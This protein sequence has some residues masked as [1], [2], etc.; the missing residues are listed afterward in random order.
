[1]AKIG[2]DISDIDKQVNSLQRELK[3]VESSLKTMGDNAVLA[4]QQYDIL[5]KAIKSTEEKLNQLR[6][7]EDAVN[8]A[9]ASGN[10]TDE[11]YRAYQREVEKTAA[12]L[13]D[14]RDK[15]SSLNPALDDST[16]E[17]KANAE[18]LAKADDQVV[19]WAKDL[20]SNLTEALTKSIELIKAFASEVVEVG[21]QFETSMSLVAGTMGI[22]QASEEFQKLEEAAK[23]TGATTRYTASQAAEALNYLALA[24]YDADQSIA[25]LPNVLNMAQS[26]GMDFARSSEM[27]TNATKTLGVDMKEVSAFVDKMA[28]TARS[29]G[30][31][32][33]QLGDAILTVGGT[34]R[35]M[36]GG[37]DEL[38]AALGILADNGIKASE[39][40]TKIRNILLKMAN[41]AKGTK[42]LMKELNVE[43][44]DM[45]GNLRPL[46]DIFGE[47]KQKM[48]DMQMT[49]QERD[50]LLGGAFNSRD[51]AAINA[52]MNTN[53][54]RWDELT[55]K[56]EAARGAAQDM[57]TTLNDNFQGAL[58]QL[59]SAKQAVEIELYQKIQA[60]LAEI[61]NSLADAVRGISTEISEAGF[62]EEFTEAFQ[63]IADAV[64]E[65]LPTI[66]ELF[67]KFSETVVPA[68]GDL[69]AKTV[70]FVADDVLPK[71]I[72]LAEWIADHGE[73]VVHVIEMLVA[74]MVANKV[75][76]FADALK[77]GITNVSALGNVVQAFLPSLTSLGET[78][79]TVVAPA[80]TTMG[81]EAEASSVALGGLAAVGIAAVIAGALAAKDAIEKATDAT[82]EWAKFANGFSQTSNDN[83]ER[84][85]KLTRMAT[86]EAGKT[87][88]EWL[89][90]DK[91]ALSGAQNALREFEKEK[92]ALEAEDDLTLM[93]ADRILELEQQIEETKKNIETYENLISAE[94]KALKK[95][96]ELD[97]YLAGADRRADLGTEGARAEKIALKNKARAAENK[98]ESEAV[99]KEAEQAEREDFANWLKQQEEMWDEKYHWDKENQAMYWIEKEKLLNENKINSKEWWDAYNKTEKALAKIR[100][101]ENKAAAKT[102]KDAAKEA[103]KEAAEAQRQLKEA[104][105]NKEKV[106][107][108]QLE[109]LDIMAKENGWK[110]TELLDAKQALL[111][112]A[113]ELDEYAQRDAEIYAKF[114]KEIRKKRADLTAENRKQAQKDEAEAE[115]K[116]LQNREDA[117]KKRWKELENQADLENWT[118]A[119]LLLEKER[120]LNDLAEKDSELY[121]TY[122]AKIDEGRAA[123]A[124]KGRKEYETEIANRQKDEQKA[125]DAGEKA[126]AKLVSIAEKTKADI[127][128]AGSG[129]TTVTDT[130]GRERLVFSDYSSKIKDLQKY[131]KQL[132][133]LKTLGL[134]DS[135]IA[136]IFQMDFNTRMKY[137][138]ELLNMGSGARAK[139]LNDYEAYQALAGKVANKELSYHNAD[140]AQAIED[141]LKDI[142]ENSYSNGAEAAEAYAK[143]WTD[144]L[145]AHGLAGVDVSQYTKQIDEFKAEN[146]TPEAKSFSALA[147]SINDFTNT[148]AG[149]QININIDNYKYALKVLN[150]VLGKG[151]NSGSKTL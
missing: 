84:Y 23:Q 111:D 43:F 109:E 15:Y 124:K 105:T 61:T 107:K 20:D 93:N 2:L 1:M 51:M 137:I 76:L 128:K 53:A 7:A 62:G 19:Q 9:H 60:P 77:T 85:V 102:E 34:A 71:A 63:K 129:T 118:E 144:Y 69:A 10:L 142:S 143:G 126:A 16:Q 79:G 149:K 88:S 47:I 5:D 38:D 78:A 145:N 64:K 36:A 55:G 103:E 6:A 86:D 125:A 4:S 25:M 42:E 45:E 52:L 72:D 32:M 151:M 50:A 138:D 119:K 68:L 22:D 140:I 54:A 11:E 31:N 44:Y 48:D 127:V 83:L 33:E 91:T 65:E 104:Q 134:S 56:I 101:A 100:T 3:T 49:Q 139:Y 106:L 21:K 35:N 57:G 75:V 70:D 116:D 87:A 114:D 12:S 24:S 37:V 94:E 59:E 30:T 28:V 74:A 27:L 39:G 97:E 130:A 146:P 14:L 135:H 150:M 117:I 58:Y 123:A 96:K 13:N 82:I 98:A 67:K 41:P 73:T 81:I 133:K 148:L 66:I 147:K 132:D 90:A 112:E 40:G 92:A 8:A 115:K 46:G 95:Q 17:I 131:S 18:E 80:L 113:R 122:Y 29:S 99:I 26:S 108:E 141:D 121:E 89:A 136:D 120:V 110:D